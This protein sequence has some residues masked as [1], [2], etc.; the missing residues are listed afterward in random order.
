MKPPV[1]LDPIKR[2]RKRF[3]Q[4][5][6]WELGSKWKAN[7]VPLLTRWQADRIAARRAAD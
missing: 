1:P 4:P 7:P 3:G 5:F 6:C 2:A